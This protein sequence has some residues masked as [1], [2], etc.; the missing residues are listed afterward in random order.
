MLRYI[1]GDELHKYPLLKKTMFLDRTAQF[2]ER[3]N[4]DVTVN[5]KGEERDE[6]DRINP[7][8][9]I[10]Q[11]ENGAHGGSMR[12]L[13]TTGDTM[14]NDHFSHLM[15]GDHIA[16]PFIWECTRFCL[17]TNAGR[18]VAPALTLAAGE[19][20]EE[21]HLKHFVGVFD[22]RMERIYSLMGLVPDVLGRS[23][24]G[25]EA[26]GVGL[27]EMK[28]EIFAPTLHRAGVTRELS[29]QW[30]NAAFG[31]QELPELYQSVA[32]A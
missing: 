6:Y 8:Y 12:F 7:L 9:V 19:I 5:E 17:S 16:S 1:Y 10:W 14:V 20:M 13:P 21:F 18:H 27:W 22:S 26:I 3:L 4:W 25:K 2:K 31:A 23:G 11:N 28:E 15:D 30:F 29:K 24:E 32:V